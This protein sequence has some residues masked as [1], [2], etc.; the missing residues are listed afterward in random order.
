[1]VLVF[2]FVLG[3]AVGSFLNVCIDRL[4][5]NKKIT[6]RSQCDFCKKKLKPIDLIPVFS[7]FQLGGKCKYCRKKLS[8]YYPFVEIVTAV[9]FVV[10]WVYLPQSEIQ[11]VFYLGLFA[12][13][14]GIFFADLKYQII[15]DEL[16]ITLFIFAFFLIADRGGGVKQL[17]EHLFSGAI[18]MLPMYLLHILTKGKGMGFGDVKLSFIIGFLLGITGGFIALYLGFAVG[19]VIGVGLLMSK[20]RKWKSK[21]AFGP[22]IVIGFI[23]VLLSG[24]RL[25]ELVRE[26]YRF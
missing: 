10:L 23:S 5:K 24:Q 11:K 3:L 22:F 25:I 8:F 26:I 18:V 13:L 19:A 7:F 20:K 12:T 15:P 16:Q 21:I 9:V 14:I 4:P 6:G 17:A 2:L 1:M